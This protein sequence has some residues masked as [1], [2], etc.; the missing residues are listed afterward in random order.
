MNRRR[1]RAAVEWVWLDWRSTASCPCS[2]SDQCQ[3]HPLLA[4]GYWE[5]GAADTSTRLHSERLTLRRLRPPRSRHSLRY[6]RSA[7]ARTGSER[8]GCRATIGRGLPVLV[9]ELEVKATCF[10]RAGKNSQS[11]SEGDSDVFSE[12]RYNFVVRLLEA[13]NCVCRTRRAHRETDSTSSIRCKR[14]LL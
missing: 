12:G 1:S 2:H 11:G 3:C 8:S 5:D 10:L 14:H 13:S 9:F 6:C 7:S 4:R